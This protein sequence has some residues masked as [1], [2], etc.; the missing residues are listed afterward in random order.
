M[1]FEMSKDASILCVKMQNGI[2]TLWALIDLDAEKVQRKFYMLPTGVQPE[3]LDFESMV[4]IDTVMHS[5]DSLVFHIFEDI[6]P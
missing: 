6:E 1:E 4:Y 2:P 5:M 3:S